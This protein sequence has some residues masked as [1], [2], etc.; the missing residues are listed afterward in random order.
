MEEQLDRNYFSSPQNFQKSISISFSPF[1]SFLDPVRPTHKFVNL[2]DL[3]EAAEAEK[4]K[5]KQKE[6]L[7]NKEKQKAK[8]MKNSFLGLLD[9]YK[10]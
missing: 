10:F 4:E 9:R 6:E 5:Q 2:D 3:R 7:E 8:N 1:A